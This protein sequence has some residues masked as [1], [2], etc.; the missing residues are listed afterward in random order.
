MDDLTIPAGETHSVSKGDTETYSQVNNSG[1]LEV[2][3][4]LNIGGK[5]EDSPDRLL[6]D[7]SPELMDWILQTLVDFT[8]A[9]C[10]PSEVIGEIPPLFEDQSNIN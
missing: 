5:V 8:T 6:H 3:G 2:S 9:N 7:I 1:T 4:E 10:D